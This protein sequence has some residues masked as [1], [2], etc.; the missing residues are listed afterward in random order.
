MS[1]L[2]TQ[3]SMIHMLS[4]G[5][6]VRS[7]LSA[8]IVRTKDFLYLPHRKSKEHFEVKLNICTK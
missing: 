8:N 2:L 3:K 5:F 7:S 6:D 1:E 4:T